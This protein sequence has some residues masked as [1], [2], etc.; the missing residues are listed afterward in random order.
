MRPCYTDFL[1]SMRFHVTAVDS[2]QSPKMK[3]TMSTADGRP[4]AGFSACSTPEVTSEAVEYREGQFIYTRKFPGVPSTADITM[5]R[6][7][8][9]RDSTFWDWMK[10]VVEGKAIPG[11]Y[12]VDLTILHYHRAEVLNGAKSPLLD[13][14]A[15]NSSPARKYVVHEA[16]PIRHKVAADL[17]ATASEVSIMEIDVA[18]EYFT[19]DDTAL[20]QEL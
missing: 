13:L 3:P 20:T 14:G 18:Y 17:D 19:V 15:D 6:G 8:A 4:D 10:E 7:V 11:N 5:A 2:S 12:R 9:R 16:F 1:H